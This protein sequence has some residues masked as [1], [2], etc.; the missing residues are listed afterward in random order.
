MSN[1]R[2]RLDSTL[3]TARRSAAVAIPLIAMAV[4][5]AGPAQAAAPRTGYWESRA[6]T[7]R[8]ESAS[9]LVQ[10]SGRRTLAAAVSAPAPQCGQLYGVF[11]SPRRL[12]RI[13]VARNGRFARRNR[14]SDGIASVRG[15]FVGR[16]PRRAI[17][18]LSWASGSCRAAQEYR[19]RRVARPRIAGGTWSGTYSGGGAINLSVVNVGR[20]FQVSALRPS[21]LFRCTDG[22][23]YRLAEYLRFNDLAW[24]APSGVFRLRDSADD[25]LVTM[26]GSFQGRSAAGTL[27]IIELFSDASGACDTGA[28]TFQVRRL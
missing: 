6:L 8:G 4:S 9:L 13:E 7:G 1:H 27:R 19:L 23:T 12:L 14:G 22:S 16:R 11:G 10:R 25:R 18:R 3:V 15:R 24:V 20:E 17:L 26:R 5:A 21:P 2:A 28:V